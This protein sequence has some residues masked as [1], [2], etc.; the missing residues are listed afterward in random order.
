MIYQESLI[1]KRKQ[2]WMEISIN[3]YFKDYHFLDKILENS[4]KL[5]IFLFI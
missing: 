1:L 4:F 3:N 5:F 2:V